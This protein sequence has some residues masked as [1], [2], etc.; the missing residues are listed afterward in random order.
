MTVELPQ[1]EQHPESVLVKNTLI[2]FKGVTVI[3]LPTN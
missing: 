2:V 1:S 3:T